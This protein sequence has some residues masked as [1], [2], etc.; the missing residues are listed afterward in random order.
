MRAHALDDR[1]RIDL[2]Q[3]RKVVCLF[4]EERSHPVVGDDDQVDPV[5]ERERL[6][7]LHQPTDHPVRQRYRLRELG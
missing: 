5:A 2:H 4:G 6:D 7:A 3:V 1:G